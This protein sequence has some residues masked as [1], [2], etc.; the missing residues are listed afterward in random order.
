[1]TD[2]I[3]TGPLIFGFSFD[4]SGK[5]TPLNWDA[6]KSGEAQGSGARVWLHLNR[7]DAEAQNCCAQKA[8]LIR[9]FAMPCCK[10][11]R[12]PVQRVMATGFSSTS[13]L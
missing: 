13:A 9:L 5:A 6:I 4:A 8:D 10:R 12:A 3:E 1:M 2:A 7:L 11:T